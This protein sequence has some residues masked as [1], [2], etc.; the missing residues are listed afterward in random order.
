MVDKAPLR[1]GLTMRQVPA[2][3]YIEPRDALA[4]NWGVFMNAALPGVQWMPLPN[5]GAERIAEHCVGWG[6]N[7]LVLTGGDDLG[8]TPMRD[9]T[10]MGLLN[11][12]RDAGHPVLGVC[13][14]LQIMGVWAGGTLMPVTGHVATRHEITGRDISVN[15]Y[16]RQALSSPVLGFTPTA[17]APDGTIEAMT[18]QRG[19]MHAIMWHPERESTP[20]PADITLFRKVFL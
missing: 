10:E 8:D 17:T 18:A 1:L 4:Q 19:A 6:I 20:D 12:A 15:S 14:G 9:N 16:H 11:W 7:A 3:G 5:L 13:R 2:P